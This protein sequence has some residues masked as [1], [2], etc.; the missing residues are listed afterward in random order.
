[1]NGEKLSQDEVEATL[2]CDELADTIFDHVY[3][4][5]QIFNTDKTPEL[6][7]VAW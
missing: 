3:W 6:Q 4:M 2:Y 5:D 7:N 1:M